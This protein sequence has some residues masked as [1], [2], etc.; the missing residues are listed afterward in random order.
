MDK[1]LLAYLAG[2]IDADGSINISSGSAKATC[3]FKL[4]AYNRDKRIIDL[5]ART[6][7]GA[8]K[9][10]R[11][12]NPKK[13]NWRPCYEWTISATQAYNAVQLLKPYLRIKIKQAELG[14]ELQELKRRYSTATKI[15]DPKLMIKLRAKYN[16]L[17]DQCM[18]LNKRGY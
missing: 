17:K 1:E 4:N 16:K 12:R 7:G 10:R 5:F 11:R 8:G 15:H 9:I 13:R 14:C 2:F 18:K 6:F 3:V